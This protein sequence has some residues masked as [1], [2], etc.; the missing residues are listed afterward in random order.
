M[1][2]AVHMHVVCTMRSIAKEKKVNL[3]PSTVAG[4]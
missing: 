2:Y 1:F 4:Q 3:S